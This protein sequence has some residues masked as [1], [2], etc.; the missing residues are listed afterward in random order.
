L[1]ALVCTP[2]VFGF[3]RTRWRSQVQPQSQPSRCFPSVAARSK[4]STPTASEDQDYEHVRLLVDDISVI[5]VVC[6]L[7]RVPWLWNDA[8]DAIMPVFTGPSASNNFSP[9]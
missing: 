9:K 8:T 5:C 7:E 3:H 1:I 6:R 2:A 4:A